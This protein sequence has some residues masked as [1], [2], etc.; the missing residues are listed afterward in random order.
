[1]VGTEK[2]TNLQNGGRNWET[3]SPPKTVVGTE[4]RADLQKGGRN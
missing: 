2:Q 4:K 3:N 1:V